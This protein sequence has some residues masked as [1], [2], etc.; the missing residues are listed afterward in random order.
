ML[1]YN[2]FYH[3]NCMFRF[4]IRAD[5]YILYY[6]Q[7]FGPLTSVCRGRVNNDVSKILTEKSKT[8]PEGATRNSRVVVSNDKI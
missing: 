5:T 8:P 6:T 7:T 2:L 1:N 4:T 3:K